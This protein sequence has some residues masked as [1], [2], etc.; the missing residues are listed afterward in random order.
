MSP[1]SKLFRRLFDAAV[2][3]AANVQLVLLPS[4]RPEEEPME[5]EEPL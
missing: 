2:Q 3:E 5:E 4:R 1:K